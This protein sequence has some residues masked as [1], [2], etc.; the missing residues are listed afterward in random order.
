VAREKKERVDAATL[1]AE[2]EKAANP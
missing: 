1:K 2:Y